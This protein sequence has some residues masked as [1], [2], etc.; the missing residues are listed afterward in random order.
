[1]ADGRGWWLLLC[2]GEGHYGGGAEHVGDGAPGIRATGG[3]G[4]DILTCNWERSG[5]VKQLGGQERGGWRRELA[6]A[7]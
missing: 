7:G 4:R 3:G 6:A 2:E 1:V 5:G